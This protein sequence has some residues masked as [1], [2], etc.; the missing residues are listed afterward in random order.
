MNPSGSDVVFAFVF[1]SIPVVDVGLPKGFAN[2]L[3]AL[4]QPII[5]QNDCRKMHENERIW[6][7]FGSVTAYKRNSTFKKV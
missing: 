4:R 3:R 6:K 5:F 2:S 1:A 7:Q